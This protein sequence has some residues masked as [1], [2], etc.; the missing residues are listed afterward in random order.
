MK[1]GV[2]AA[3]LLA[4]SCKDEGLEKHKQ[5]LDA[6]AKCLEKGARPGDACFTP[7]VALLDAV[8]KDSSAHAKAA[9]LKE[10]LTRVA[11]PP[12][13]APLAIDGPC[14]KL[15]QELG[16]TPEAQRA[17]K[18]KALDACRKKEKEHEDE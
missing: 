15:A 1:R 9:A 3:L 13:R 12:P 10:T 6:Y 16:T 14:A 2:L 8:P 4:A 11:P 5:A 17:E 18:L 7:V